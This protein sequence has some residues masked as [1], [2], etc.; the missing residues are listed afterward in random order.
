MIFNDNSAE[1]RH[2]AEFALSIAQNVHANIILGNTYVKSTKPVEKVF[3]GFDEKSGPYEPLSPD[4]LAHLKLMNNKRSSYKPEIIETD[5]SQMNE[6]KVAELINKNNIWMIVKG[7]VDILHEISPGKSLNVRSI[8][9]KV[10]CPLMLVPMDWQ[11]KEMERLV[12]IADL[13]YCRIQVVKYLAAIA[14]PVKASLLIA[15]LTANGLPDMEEK[16]ALNVFTEGIS[17]NV[18][19]DNLYFNNIKEKDLKRAVDVIINGMHN[20]L[21]VLVNHRFHFEE[22]MGRHKANN[23]PI[24]VTVPLLI[25]PF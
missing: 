1:A 18:Q 8:L 16:Y 20:D 5:I 11:L 2:A 22:I 25:F 14:G 10:L 7:A 19:Y 4:L 12:Y 15:H 9:N 3:A 17:N 23:Q 13:R 6:A 24:Q 21:L